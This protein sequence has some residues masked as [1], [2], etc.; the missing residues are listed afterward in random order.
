MFD[1]DNYAFEDLLDTFIQCMN[2]I[3]ALV[4]F[5]CVQS[6]D[7]CSQ[8]RAWIKILAGYM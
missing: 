6:I 4:A 3:D 2:E 8:S 5:P 1:L 7:K